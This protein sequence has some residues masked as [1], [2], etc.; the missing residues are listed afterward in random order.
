MLPEEK[1]TQLDGIVQ[2]ML[3]N[4]EPDSNIRFVVDD[5]K[6]KYNVPEL[7]QAE[8][9]P[10]LQDKLKS[11]NTIEMYKGAAKGIG[12]TVTGLGQLALK[13]AKKIAPESWGNTI[14]GGIDYGDELKNTTFKAQNTGQFIGKGVEQIGEFFV[15]G[16][17]ATKLAKVTEAGIGA[18]KLAQTVPIVGKAL[19]L[20]TKSGIGAAE[21][22]GVTTA[23]TGS[24]EEGKDAAKFGAAIPV[25]GT[26]IGKLSN[27]LGGT[28]K[29][30]AKKIE[31]VSL[32]LSPV[33]K[34][35]LG[36]RLD[37]VTEFLTNHSITGNPEQRFQKVEELYNASEETLSSFIK[38]YAPTVEADTNEIIKQ[39]KSIAGKFKNDR[40]IIAIEKQ[41]AEFVDLMKNRYKNKI[42]L[43]A[44]N[45]LKRSTFKGAYN[46]A[47]SKV[48]DNIEHEIGNV[49]NK[50]IQK[51][52]NGLEVAGQDIKSFN[53][54]YG[55]L[56]ESKKLLD[57]A[58][59]RPELGLVGKLIASSVGG[60]VG[61]GIGG[62]VGTALGILAGQQGGK[63]LAG[64]AMRSQVAKVLTKLSKIGKITESEAGTIKNFIFGGGNKKINLSPKEQKI[65]NK[66]TEYVNNPKVGM[67]IQDVSKNGSPTVGKTVVSK[68]SPLIQEARKTN[69]AHNIQEI[70]NSILEGKNILRTG[71]IDG[72]TLS[73]EELQQV[74]RSVEN[75]QKKIGTEIKEGYKIQE[76]SSDE[77]FGKT[78]GFRKEDMTKEGLRK[79]NILVKQGKAEIRDGKYY[80]SQPLQEGVKKISVADRLKKIKNEELG[81]MSDFT[82]FV[83]G[84]Y[85]LTAQEAKQLLGEV[86]SIAKRHG[87]KIPKTKESLANAFDKILEKLKYKK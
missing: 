81:T 26:I 50:N 87:I 41:L 82:D 60:A 47:G 28:S 19:N 27:A 52:T 46:K 68:E 18:T 23:Q 79:W 59:T 75:A 61:T 38:K 69:D 86:T 33:Q 8:Q 71:K 74:S 12:S 25:A 42:P 36:K 37:D 14:Q 44:L 17:A 67:S 4:K 80:K 51:I 7:V 73:P 72:R 6:K 66:I 15:P 49:L 30:L 55:T 54:V 34:K 13:G 84:T 32:R 2:D 16:G 45:E 40:D 1:R 62:G 57:I 21:V 22:G 64:T 9:K 48:L 24:I 31:Q 56:I 43:D 85:K 65:A 3:R 83:D 77:V 10:S 5:F 70:K 20:A 78:G 11:I 76:L 29:E 63:L 58:R 53:K 35:N 39:V